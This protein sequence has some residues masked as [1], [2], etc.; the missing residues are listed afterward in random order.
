MSGKAGP[1]G[2]GSGVTPVNMG[3]RR[4]CEK[5]LGGNVSIDVNNG[6]AQN[7]HVADC[8]ID[9]TH[10]EIMRLRWHKFL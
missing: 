3:T 8:Q 5:K 6:L 9:L 2:R 1:E 7:V 10:Y 4:A